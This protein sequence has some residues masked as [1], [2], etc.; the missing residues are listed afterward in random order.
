M[1]LVMPC[2]VL[3]EILITV[4]DDSA[5]MM[6]SITNYELQFNVYVEYLI[7]KL[8]NVDA[9]AEYRDAPGC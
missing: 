6:G 2:L 8:Y 7:Y 1:G 9:N 5:S 3:S 4:T